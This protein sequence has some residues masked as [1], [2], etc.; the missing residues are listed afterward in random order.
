VL[1]PACLGLNTGLAGGAE[2]VGVLLLLLLLLLGLSHTAA[3]QAVQA[4]GLLFHCM[5]H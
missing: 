3:A 4:V 5:E 2:T 1:P